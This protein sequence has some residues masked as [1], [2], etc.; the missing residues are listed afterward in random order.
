MR[1]VTR[2]SYE[3]EIDVLRK[4]LLNKALQT[5]EP[6]LTRILSKQ[7]S[8]FSR[9]QVRAVQQYVLSEGHV[10]SV[11][12]N[13]LQQRLLLLERRI[14][15]SDQQRPQASQPKTSMNFEREMNMVRQT[16]GGQAW[17]KLEP[18]LSQVLTAQGRP[19]RPGTSASRERV[20]R[21]RRIQPA[22]TRR[23]FGEKN[24]FHGI[25]RP[26]LNANLSC[27]AVGKH[28][29]LSINVAVPGNSS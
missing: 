1:V 14:L 15:P 27:S 8:P 7:G 20:D 3:N 19:P 28:S 18:Q 25:T 23:V 12:I 22:F 13:Y 16:L 26:A 6:A 17:S 9:D 5:L 24:T 2:L 21:A 10:S 4:D 29:G 11:D